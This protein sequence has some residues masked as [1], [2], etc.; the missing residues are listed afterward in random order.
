MNLERVK[1]L[2]EIER[3]CVSRGDLCDRDC[4]NCELVQETRELLEA[5]K[6]V[7]LE[8]EDRILAIEALKDFKAR[9]K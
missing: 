5:Y 9:I 1:E 3:E 8:L 7:I 6:I 4:K 2:M